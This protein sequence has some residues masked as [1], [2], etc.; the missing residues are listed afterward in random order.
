MHVQSVI[1][2]T[3]GLVVDHIVDIQN[4]DDPR[5]VIHRAVQTL[6]DDCLVAFPTETC[7]VVGASSQSEIAVRKL[8]KFQPTDAIP[9]TLAVKGADE[10]LDFVPEMSK[11]GRKLIHR[12]WPGPVTLAFDVGAEPGLVASL[13][14]TTQSAI[15][16]NRRIRLRV[17]AHGVFNNVQRLVPAPIVLGR[18]TSSDGVPHISAGQIASLYGNDVSLVIADGACRY[19]QPAS[20]VYVSNDDWE[21]LE[22][23]VVTETTVRRLACEVYLF[24]CTGNTCRSPMAEAMFRRQLAEK[25]QCREDE[26]ADRG[27]V[28]ISAGLAAAYGAPANPEAVRVLE[29]IGIDLRSHE[30]QPLTERLLEQADY[31]FTMT[32]GHQQAILY[33]RPALADRVKLLSPEGVDISDPIGGNTE[34]YQRCRQE[35]ERHL[36]MILDSISTK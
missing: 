19:G 34:Q 9:A 7:Y 31:I 21:M 1:P 5:D 10:A 3:G 36:K 8:Q 22:Q 27:F 29:E 26:L 6:A 12:C 30:S 17:P 20:V 16:S 23:G 4:A 28:V 25:L 24:V 13:P 35:V 11:L 2:I 32:R 15:I 33:E 14:E 18:E